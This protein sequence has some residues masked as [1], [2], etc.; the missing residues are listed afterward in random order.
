RAAPRAGCCRHSPPPPVGLRTVEPVDRG[1]MAVSG[2]GHVEIPM[3]GRMLARPRAGQPFGHGHGQ[4]ASRLV[5]TD[6]NRGR[7][8]E[9][10]AGGRA[11]P[12]GNARSPASTRWS[13]A[14]S[15]WASRAG[16]PA[17]AADEDGPGRGNATAREAR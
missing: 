2:S 3:A 15:G 4:V 13:R 5:D 10:P 16:P 8:V 7:P 17:P 14:G 6:E 12:P 9:G 11:G 1:D